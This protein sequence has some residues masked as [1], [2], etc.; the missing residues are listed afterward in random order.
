MKR[1]VL[2]VLDSIGIGAMPD[3]ELYGDSGAN[4]LGHIA[5]AMPDFKIPNLEKLGLGMID[6]VTNIKKIDSPMGSYGR[7]QEMSKGK[8]TITGHWEIA[9]LYTDVPFKTFE[10]FPEDFMESFEKAIG[11]KTLGNYA[12]SGTKIIE[13]LGP[14]HEKTGKP[15]IYTSADSVFQIAANTAVIPLE[16]LYHICEVARKMLVG[17]ML[18][19]RVIARPYVLKDGKRS[20]RHL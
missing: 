20:Q 8:D 13:D 1:V 9:G 6:G 12:A 10:K 3:A 7:L 4:T 18:V 2:I 5:E 15:I 16:K 14:E 17:D 11:V 19:G